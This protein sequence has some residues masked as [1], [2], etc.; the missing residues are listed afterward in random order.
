MHDFILLAFS[1]N[2]C[3]SGGGRLDSVMTNCPFYSASANNTSK[4]IHFHFDANENYFHIKGFTQD[5][6]FKRRGSCATLVPNFNTNQIGL[7]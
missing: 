2:I 7:A 3:R 6:I 4:E 5:L 1:L